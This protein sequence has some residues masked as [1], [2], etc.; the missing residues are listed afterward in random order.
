MKKC[1][2]EQRTVTVSFQLYVNLR[3]IFQPSESKRQNQ[4]MVVFLQSACSY[5]VTGI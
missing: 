3:D 2:T 5:E 1:S 4:G